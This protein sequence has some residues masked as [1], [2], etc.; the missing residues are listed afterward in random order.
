MC[1]TPSV[2]A[3]GAGGGER[4]TSRPSALTL[5]LTPWRKPATCY[6]M[7]VSLLS[8]SRC[9]ASGGP[10]VPCGGHALHCASGDL[11]VAI[12][13]IWCALAASNCQSVPWPSVYQG[14]CVVYV[15]HGCCPRTVVA[16]CCVKWYCFCTVTV[17]MIHHPN[18]CINSYHTFRGSC[19]GR[20]Y[21]TPTLRVPCHQASMGHQA[22]DSPT[23]CRAYTAGWSQLQLSRHHT[24]RSHTT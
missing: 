21:M 9:C 12:V 20:G 15:H 14:H 1:P 3:V 24:K 17:F 5:V 19:H 6:R 7:I 16:W 22:I 18:Y 23:I 11:L 4:H 8:W 10:L 13:L 2:C